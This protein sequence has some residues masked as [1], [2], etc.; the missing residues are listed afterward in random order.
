MSVQKNITTMHPDINQ[1]SLPIIHK[2]DGQASALYPKVK[3]I[4]SCQIFLT[5]SG[6]KFM[7][8]FRLL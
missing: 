2:I 1:L 4:N 7:E 6:N 5:S 8:L 3:I